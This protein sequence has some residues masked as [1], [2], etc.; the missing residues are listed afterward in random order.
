MSQDYKYTAA[1][2]DRYHSGQMSEGEMHALEKA[3]LQDPFLADALEGYAYTDAATKDITG[4]KEKL[5]SKKK[6]RN[7]FLVIQKQNSWLKIA[8]LFILIAGMG[9]MAYLLNFNKGNNTLAKKENGYIKNTTEQIPTPKT[10][11]SLSNEKK[12]IVITTPAEKRK[13]AFMNKDNKIPAADLKVEDKP[14]EK[15]SGYLRDANLQKAVM[16]V[17]QKNY[18][19]NGEKNFLKGKIVDSMGYPVRYATIAS[20]ARNVITTSDSTGRFKLETNDSS[21]TATVSAPGYKTREKK[22]S[23]KGEQVIVI[24]SDNQNL[25]EVAVTA[26]GTQRQKQLRS[27]PKL[28]GKVQGIAVDNTISE[29]INGWKKFNEYILANINIPEDENGNNYKG[30]VVLSFEINTKGHLKKIKVE[31]SL[32][33]PCDEEA[34]RLLIQGPKWK[35]VKDKRPVVTIQF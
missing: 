2:F 20:K 6:K 12:D 35:Y 3:A 24:K 26:L 25:N 29:P 14:V 7:V 21:L 18:S 13:E 23:D 33:T 22:L 32:C 30:K 16:P 15:S 34:G 31:E 10:G 9:Y 19:I 17:A 8:A 5:F 11:S 1:D 28:E 4:L 27:A